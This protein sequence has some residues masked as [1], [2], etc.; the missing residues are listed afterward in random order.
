MTRII[1]ILNNP[2]VK[3]GLKAF[4]RFPLSAFMLYALMIS[5]WDYIRVMFMFYHSLEIIFRVIEDNG[6]LDAD[7]SNQHR[8]GI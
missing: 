5:Q 2:L 1:L 3:F 7:F 6:G 4:V 8:M